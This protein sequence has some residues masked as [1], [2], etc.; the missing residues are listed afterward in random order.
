[1]SESP[2]QPERQQF[3]RF[4]PGSQLS[5]ADVILSYAVPEI[6]IDWYASGPLLLIGHRDWGDHPLPDRWMR[7]RRA[8]LA[9]MKPDISC[10][11]MIPEWM[12]REHQQLLPEP[13]LRRTD[14]G[15]F[16]V[17]VWTAGE[18]AT[19]DPRDERALR[20]D[21]EMM[22]CG[23]YLWCTP[24][25][26]PCTIVRLDEVVSASSSFEA[27]VNRIHRDTP[28]PR[29]ARRLSEDEEAALDRVAKKHHRQRW[30]KRR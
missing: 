7:H 11:L 19:M 27:A 22:T 30:R 29:P 8:T 28:L 21:V 3:F 6:D 15:V 24:Q 17:H 4:E 13:T 1:M 25:E 9:S 5:A 18:F 20:N 26:T 2:A 16:R 23:P 14:L 12:S 10:V